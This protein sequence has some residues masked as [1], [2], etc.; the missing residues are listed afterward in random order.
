[1]EILS[2]ILAFAFV[3]FSLLAIFTPVRKATVISLLGLFLILLS[4]LVASLLTS[5]VPT[6]Q[7][8]TGT[9]RTVGICIFVWGLVESVLPSLHSKSETSNITSSRESIRG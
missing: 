7:E 2:L 3:A 5:S 8:W 4:P 9:F 1:M 6:F